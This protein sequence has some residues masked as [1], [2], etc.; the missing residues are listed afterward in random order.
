MRNYVLLIRVTAALTSLSFVITLIIHYGF[1]GSEADFWCNICL[2]IFGSGLLTFITS[3]IGYVS[4]KRRTMEGFAYSTRALIHMLNKYDLDWEL[5]RK[6]D[7]F[8]GYSDVDKALWDAQ[9]GDIIFLYDPHKKKREYIY[10]AI[11]KPI[12]DLNNAI[13]R[14]DAHFKWHKDG[15][16]KNDAVMAKFVL[17]IESLFMEKTTVEHAI[18]DGHTFQ[19]TDIQNKLVHSVLEELNGKYY[20]IMYGKQSKSE[21]N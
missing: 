14:H 5:E 18:G 19:L 11:Y 3:C 16:G 7:F 13:A 6:I 17:E 9:F 10:Q 20:D 1:C 8:L 15:S 4:E 12:L 2:A 21:D